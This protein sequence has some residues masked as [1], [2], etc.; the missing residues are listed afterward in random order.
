VGIEALSPA[1]SATMVDLSNDN[2]LVRP[3]P[4]L[5]EPDAH[6]QAAML[7]VESLIHGLIARSVIQVADAIDMVTVA[8]EVKMEIAADLGDN[9][10]TKDKTLGL[11]S[12]IRESLSL[13]ID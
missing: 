6:G 8:I 7:L 13:D 4:G 9:Q 1:W 3:V 11:L 12:V 5:H 2:E 10:D